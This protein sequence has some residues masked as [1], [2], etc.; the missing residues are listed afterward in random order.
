MQRRHRLRR[1]VDFDLLRREG[2]R[3]H[4]PLFLLVVRANNQQISR[5][6]YSTSRRVG[7]A[8][9]RNRVKRLLREVVRRRLQ[10]IESGWDCL[11]IARNGAVEASFIE[12]E[13]AVIELLQRAGLLNST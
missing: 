10:E 5:F 4:H 11:F 2:K 7:K 1:T 12:L 9:S 3:W 6:G 8:T 13:T